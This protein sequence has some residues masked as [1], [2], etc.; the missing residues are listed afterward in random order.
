MRDGT[1][2]VAY[3]AAGRPAVAWIWERSDGRLGAR[4]EAQDPGPAHD[5][6]R[7]LL[8]LDV[9]HGPFLRRARADPLLR[10]VAWRHA[11]LRPLRRAT[12]A[13]ALVRALCGQVVA[14]AE[15]GRI[16][17]ALLRRCTDSAGDLRVPPTAADVAGLA[18]AEAV[19]S[20]LAARRAAAL[21]RVAREVPLERLR[22]LSAEALERRVRRERGLGPWSLGV[23]GLYG[24]GRYE[25]G[26]VGDLGLKKLFAAERGRWPEDHET[27]ELIARY[28]E[29]AGLASVYLLQH[30]LATAHG[31]PTAR[32][33]R[34]RA[35]TG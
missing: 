25:H 9:D 10:E 28:E 1:L 22:E 30:P 12:V 7:F 19:A 11:G 26:L 6:L 20:G 29:W 21:V 2:A 31:T 15:A 17:R 18:P 27:A 32:Q 13:H 14:G 3:R 16:E 8:A 23:I 34:P 35:H 5:A 33:W 24:L 4:I